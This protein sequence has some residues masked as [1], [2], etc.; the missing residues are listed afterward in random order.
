[1]SLCVCLDL[2]SQP[3]YS[4]S[5]DLRLEAQ[6]IRATQEEASTLSQ[7]HPV[8]I[9]VARRLR[10]I[11][12]KWQNFQEVNRKIFVAPPKKVTCVPLSA[13]CNLEVKNL[14][15]NLLEVKLLGKKGEA[16]HSVTQK[17]SRKDFLVI[18]GDDQAGAAWFVVIRT[19]P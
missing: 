18:G 9:S 2:A 3:G 4:Q 13:S 11:N 15:S 6:L 10:A 7:N 19:I 5:N 12:L 17:V 1:M 14:G 8:E 16:A